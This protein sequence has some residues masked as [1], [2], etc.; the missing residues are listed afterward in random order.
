M[1]LQEGICRGNTLLII[2][3]YIHLISLKKAEKGINRHSTTK[4]IS[5]N[6]P[7]SPPHRRGYQEITYFTIF[8]D[9][10]Q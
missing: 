9:I 6:H 8:L 1:V 2:F 4:G 10:I 3:E 5:M 7:L